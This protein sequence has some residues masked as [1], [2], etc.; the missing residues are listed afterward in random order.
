MKMAA[1]TPM[2][3]KN[4]RCHPPASARNEKAA[5]W[6]CTRT[7]LKNPV[8]GVLSPSWKAPSTSTL[9]NWS[10]TSTKRAMPSQSAMPWLLLA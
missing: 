5:P 9:V 8:M 2:P 10:S 6:L 1:K 3:V 7:R 4:Q